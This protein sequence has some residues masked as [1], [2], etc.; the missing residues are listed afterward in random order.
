MK[1]LAGI[2]VVGAGLW[3]IGLAALITAA[4]PR[5]ERFLSGF[6]SSARSH[7]IEQLCRM[8]V[9]VG[10]VLYAA[11]M[12]FQEM[13]W[14]FGW[15]IIVTTSGLFLIPWRWHREFGKWAIPLAIRNVRLYAVGA[16]V[17]GVFMLYAVFA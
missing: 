8:I 6:A 7:Y 4:R 17:L 16:F 2:V 10:I 9:G 5:A 3:L 14:I 13:F 1:W 15:L 11:E 12:R